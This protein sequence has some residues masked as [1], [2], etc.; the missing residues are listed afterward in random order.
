M[1]TDVPRLLTDAAR[2]MADDPDPFVRCVGMLLADAARSALRSDPD[3]MHVF[4][5]VVDIAHAYRR[6][7][8]GGCE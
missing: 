4:R 2:A 6:T 7:R 5:S 3:E 1:A 8:N